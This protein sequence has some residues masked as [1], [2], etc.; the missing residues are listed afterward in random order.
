MRK[1]FNKPIEIA[2]IHIRDREREGENGLVS[3]PMNSLWIW[4]TRVHTTA[5]W[6]SLFIYSSVRLRGAV[7][8]YLYIPELLLK[9]LHTCT[10]PV[11]NKPDQADADLVW[12]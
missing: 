1:T 9:S 4:P 5:Q 7:T 10:V 11:Y 3:G 2:P 12:V 6:L 8:I